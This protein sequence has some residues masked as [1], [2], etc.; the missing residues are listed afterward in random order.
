MPHRMLSVPAIM[1]RPRRDAD[2]AFVRAALPRVS[3]TFAINIRLLSGE[4]GDAVRVGY[5]LCR[6]ADALEDSWPGGVAQAP[7]DALIEAVRGD[8]AAADRVAAAAAPLAHGRADLE[9]VAEFPRVWRVHMA[10]PPDARAAIA[11]GV[12]TLASGM[13]EFGTRAAQRPGAAY[14]ETERELHEYCF[15]VAGCVGI[16][17]TRLFER[18][19]HDA[20]AE[21]RA[22][23]LALAPAVGEALQ[24]TNILLDWP[25]DVRRG[26]CYLPAAWLAE[27]GLSPA[28]LVRAADAGADATP[29]PGVR[30]I[31]ARIERLARAAL[32][33]VPSYVALI[34]RRHWRYRLFCLWPALWASDSLDHARSD[35]DF[36]WGARRPRLPRPRLWSAAWR[37]ALGLRGAASLARGS[38]PGV[39]ASPASPSSA[40]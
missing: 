21:R 2:R 3:R 14:L 6:A 32:A 34:P 4:L 39:I 27:H 29:K 18:E 31:V 28:D 10:L 15:V 12:T 24:L 30:E 5:L 20:S 23:R 33:Q 17:L 22:R 13:R 36:P 40:R 25:A 38:A 19:A 11:E 16:M 26:R 8:A 9:L 7:F 35:A 37:S 1:E